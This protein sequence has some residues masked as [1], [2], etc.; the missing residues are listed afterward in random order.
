MRQSFYSVPVR[1]AGTRVAVVLG[2]ETVEVRDGGQVV[3]RHPRAIRRG[4]ETLQLD[5]YLEVLQVKPGAFASSTALGQARAAG[6][7][8]KAHDRFYNL[9][10]ARLGDRDG[11][12][13]MIEVLLAHRILPH[14]AVVA[15]IEAALSVSCVDAQVVLVE[16]RR[17][18]EEVAERPALPVGLTRFDRPAP[19]LSG[20][21]ELLEA[22]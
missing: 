12:K 8:T 21:D 18:T 7:F 16:A 14:A 4:Q 5:H 22:K 13:A 19:S 1:Y 15:G 2:A 11:T 9:A 3:A 17:A 6:R 20:Y 10:R